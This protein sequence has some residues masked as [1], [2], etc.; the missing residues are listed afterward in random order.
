[1]KAGLEKGSSLIEVV[2]SIFFFSIVSVSVYN[3]YYQDDSK[4]Y[5]YNISIVM[6]KYADA[7]SDYLQNND[8]SGSINLST[9][10]SSGYL[11]QS[12][13]DDP[14]S[15]GEYTI[16]LYGDGKGNGLVALYGDELYSITVKSIGRFLGIR[17]AYVSDSAITSAGEY[18]SLPSSDFTGFT[19]TNLRGLM[20]VPAIQTSGQNCNRGGYDF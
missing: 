10:I 13:N 20:L 15:L 7:L 4:H 11:P 16:K 12:S 14:S 3:Y 1:M 9:L 6:C 18:Y 19:S 2:I 8:V 17:G 5:M